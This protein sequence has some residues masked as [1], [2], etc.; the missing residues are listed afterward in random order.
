MYSHG[1]HYI[2]IHVLNITLCVLDTRSSKQT[3]R[4]TYEV[5]EVTHDDGW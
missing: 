2:S 3:I 1:K 4:E 5:G